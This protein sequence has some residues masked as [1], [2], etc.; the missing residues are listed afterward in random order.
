M[1][2]YIINV[3]LAPHQRKNGSILG[4]GHMQKTV[5]NSKEEKLLSEVILIE[6]KAIFEEKY[7]PAIADR[8]Y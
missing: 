2:Y 4:F 8:K 3:I 5:C 6:Y 7:T 1:F